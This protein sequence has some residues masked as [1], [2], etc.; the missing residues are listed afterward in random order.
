[1]WS[2]VEKK[3]VSSSS[4]DLNELE[5]IERGH[6]DLQESGFFASRYASFQS[7]KYWF[8]IYEKQN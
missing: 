2:G 6:L 8:L 4:V 7:L 5:E 3:N 1:M